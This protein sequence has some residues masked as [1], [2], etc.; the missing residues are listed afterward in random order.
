MNRHI[1]ANG[2]VEL[3]LHPEDFAKAA[4][5]RGIASEPAITLYATL[6][7]LG[8]DPVSAFAATLGEFLT[9]RLEAAAEA[10][11]T[12]EKTPLFSR[13]AE[14]IEEAVGAARIRK[15]LAARLTEASGFTR[16]AAI[17][18]RVEFSFR[19][20]AFRSAERDAAEF[21]RFRTARLASDRN[22]NAMADEFDRVRREAN[23]S[24]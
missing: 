24:H 19:G 22:R 17:A 6:R 7:V 9:C 15:E 23:T 8:H 12:F 10:M 18:A 2:D 4:V 5:V 20:A 14:E 3:I 21:D 1:Y 13:L 16:D 11:E